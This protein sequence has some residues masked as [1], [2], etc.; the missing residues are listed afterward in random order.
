MN[1]QEL[2]IKGLLGILNTKGKIDYNNPGT[3]Y[4]ISNGMIGPFAETY[5]IKETNKTFK[6]FETITF[7]KFKG[8]KVYD[9]ILSSEK[10]HNLC[11]EIYNESS[12]KDRKKKNKNVPFY[13]HIE[14]KIVTY[15]KLQKLNMPTENEIKNV[16]CRSRLVLLT[17]EE[18]DLLD[19]E[20][21]IKED[22]DILKSWLDRNLISEDDYNF[23]LNIV[24]KTCQ[25]NGN[26]FARIAHLKNKG[27]NFY[28]NGIL[29]RDEDI[30]EYLENKNMDYSI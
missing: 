13:E 18:K 6:F 25:S 7:N 15:K 24:D 22:L 16:M 11:E 19:K 23:N 17:Y 9:Y 5:Y 2:C 28:I 10:G 4:M 12:H 26:S 30:I 14:P 1:Y 3:K 8:L 21:F 29:A 20:T 27:I